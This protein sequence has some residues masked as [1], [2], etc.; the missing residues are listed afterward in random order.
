MLKEASKFIEGPREWMELINKSLG[1]STQIRIKPFALYLGL[2]CL[3]VP[4]FSNRVAVSLGK[5][6][7]KCQKN[8]LRRVPWPTGHPN[9][10]NL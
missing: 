9:F 8:V 3:P 4:L 10:P 1:S 5:E 2:E 7:L 6:I